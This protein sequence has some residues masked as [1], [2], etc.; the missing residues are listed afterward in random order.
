MSEAERKIWEFSSN[1][2]VILKWIL[3]YT[4]WVCGLDLSGL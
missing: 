3:Q 4:V 1:E 2:R